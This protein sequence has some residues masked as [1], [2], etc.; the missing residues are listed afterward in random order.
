MRAL[1]LTDQAGWVRCDA[2]EL[3]LEKSEKDKQPGLSGERMSDTKYPLIESMGLRI[4]DPFG[5]AYVYADDLERVLRE[6]PVVYGQIKNIDGQS[7]KDKHWVATQI[8]NC[9]ETHTARLVCIQ[10]IKQKTREE[11]LEEL[12][13]EYLT[14]D[15]DFRAFSQVAKALLEEKK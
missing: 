9:G 7:T 2:V 4:A 13:R 1:G 15:M 8:P 5:V 10:P 11:R 3:A 6:A 14:A 12:V